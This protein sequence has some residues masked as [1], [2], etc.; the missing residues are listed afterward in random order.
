M[1]RRTSFLEEALRW[2]DAPSHATVVTARAEDAARDPELAESFDL[3]VVRSF[4]PPAVVAECAARFLVVGGLLVV[5]EPPS[6]PEGDERWPVA[7]LAQLG[8]EGLGVQRFGSA[9]QVI[10]KVEPTS[11]LFPRRSGVP[12][13]RPLF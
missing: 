10:K 4:G 6:S 13:K 12:L 9:F 2:Q 8:L 3:V 5:S 1:V 11:D 7:G